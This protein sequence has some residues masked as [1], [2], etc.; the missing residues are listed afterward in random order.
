MT[1][2]PPRVYPR[3]FEPKDEECVIVLFHYS[4]ITHTASI[5]S[6]KRGNIGEEWIR[7]F[8]IE[9]DNFS[10]LDDFLKEDLEF[11]SE[12]QCARALYVEYPEPAQGRNLQA[13][14]QKAMAEIAVRV[15]RV[16]G[17]GEAS[18]SRLQRGYI[19]GE[20]ERVPGPK[21]LAQRLIR[22]IFDSVPPPDHDALEDPLHGFHNPPGIENRWIECR[23]QG[24][25]VRGWAIR[26][27]VLF[28][29]LRG[30][31]RT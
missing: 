29:G 16:W 25:R 21:K 27:R 5:V 28:D 19:L 1:I 15:A 26:R 6:V 2:K 30:R 10:W 13:E 31:V 22:R 24:A 17:S 8:A 20:F 14:A 18:Y 9:A 3:A 7:S 11:Y 23:A 4:L 12:G